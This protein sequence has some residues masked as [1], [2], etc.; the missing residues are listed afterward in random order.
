MRPV[1]RG[2][3]PVNHNH[4]PVVYND[5]KDARDDLIE[6]MGDYCS[7]CEVALNSQVDVEHVLPK[8]LNPDHELDWSNFLLACGNCNSIKGNKDIDLADYY[9]PDIDNTLRALVYEKD[10]PPQVVDDPDVDS[11]RVQETLDLTGLDRIPGHPKFSDRDRRWL[12]R[13]EAWGIAL[14]VAS[15][16]KVD[17]S[18]EMREMAIEVAIG[19][20][21]WSVWLHVFYDDIDMCQRL[22]KAFPGT[23]LECFDDDTNFVPRPGGAL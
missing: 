14:R 5:Y 6:R 9:W 1:I 23:A 13:M 21:F 17:D 22:I 18:D 19:R 2:D 7:Y 3:V 10:M 12:K 15:L 16:L 20:G 4:Q 11:D 8:S